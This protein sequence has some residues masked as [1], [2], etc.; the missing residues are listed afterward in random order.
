M[1]RVLLAIVVGD[2]MMMLLKE[3][4]MCTPTGST[5][6]TPSWL[7]LFFFVPFGYRENETKVLVLELWVMNYELAPQQALL[8]SIHNSSS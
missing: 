5:T 3:A 4:L 7:C 6:T 1:P 2:G 8:A